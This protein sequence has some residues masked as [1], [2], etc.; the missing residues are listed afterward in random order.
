[1]S[2]ANM[3]FPFV[4]DIRQSLQDHLGLILRLIKPEIS[5]YT[6]CL[7]KRPERLYGRILEGY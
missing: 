7:E 5:L 6:P 1:M 4:K 3:Q 2:V